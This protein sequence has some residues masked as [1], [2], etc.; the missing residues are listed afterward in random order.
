MQHYKLPIILFISLLL[1]AGCKK[2]DLTAGREKSP[3]RSMGDFIRNNYDLSLL[4]AALEKTGLLDTLN[5]PGPFTFFAPDNKA[6]NDMGITSAS[7]F[8]AMNADSLRFALKCQ[9]F[10]DRKYVSDFPLQMGNKYTTLAGTDMYV[11]CSAPVNGGTVPVESRFLYVNGS[12]VHALP[13]R[14][15]ALAN[16]VVHIVRKPFHYH[17]TNIQD[18]LQADTSF[19][20]FVTAMKRFKLW[21]GLKENGPLTVFAPNNDAFRKNYLTADSIN[22]MDPDKFEAVAFGIYPLMLQQRHIFITD[23]SQI[24]VEYAE[25]SGYIKVPGFF[26]RPLY[27]YNSYNNQERIELQVF[28]GDKQPGTNGPVDIHYHRG[29]AYGADHITTNGIVHLVD[30]LLLYPQTLRK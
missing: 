1:M 14:N 13:K 19:S 4:A 16:G 6:F 9:V 12:I 18:F 21:D 15:L 5:Q 8:N 2:D 10:R 20:L 24:N 29:Y 30:D 22:R 26:I 11:S 27:E 28:N 17:T 3:T 25:L 23:W 7:A